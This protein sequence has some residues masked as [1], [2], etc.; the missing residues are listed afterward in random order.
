MKTLKQVCKRC[1]DASL[2]VYSSNIRRLYYI[3]SGDR[4]KKIEELPK[5]KAWLMSKKLE[6]GY[7]KFGNNVKRHLSSSAFIATKLYGIKEENKWNKNML[8]DASEYEKQRN[9]NKKS[10]YENKNLLKDGIKTLKNGIRQYRNEIKHIFKS[11]TKQNLYKY[12]NYLALKMMS[13]NTPF[14]NDLAT[15][16]VEKE[17]GNYLTKSKNTYKIHMNDFKNSKI[18]GP[19]V[20]ELNRANSGEMK[21]F[22]KFRHQV[23]IEHDYLFSLKNGK[24]MSKSA[25]SQSLLALTSRL[26]GG[27][28]IG[29]RLI[30]VMVASANEELLKKADK[31]SH[32][33]LHSKSGA[34]T[35]QYVRKEQD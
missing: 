26:F 6:D 24:K 19:R 1:S 33:M 28:K 22:L 34:Q 16:N 8:K 10:D 20:I 13:G 31:L 3:Y 29:S 32:D 9:K 27:K 23:G 7:N 25:F 4:I 18:L 14:R 15:I 35:R 11:P 2:K 30:R 12:Q 5:T 17:E 21:K